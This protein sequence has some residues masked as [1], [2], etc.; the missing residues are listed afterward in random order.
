[1]PDQSLQ[2]FALPQ[3]IS[4]HLSTGSIIGWSLLLVF[5]L[6]TL[7]TLVATYHWIRYSH[8]PRVALPAIVVHLAVSVALMSFALSGAL[9][10]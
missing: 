3:G 9:L 4:L 10:L 6:W 7:Y 1:M 2:P 5:L 8:A